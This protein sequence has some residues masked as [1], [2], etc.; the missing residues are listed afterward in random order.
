[1]T[2]DTTIVSNC[3]PIPD[4]NSVRNF[5]EIKDK[6]VRSA[7]AIMLE[8]DLVRDEHRWQIT[9]L[10]LYLFHP[11][12][13]PDDSTDK[14]DA[15]LESGKWY[16]R[17]DRFA[18]QWRIDITAGTIAGKIHAG[19]LIGA[20]GNRDGSGNAVKTI[21]HGESRLGD[22][23]FSSKESPESRFVKER[24]HGRPIHNAPPY[25]RLEKRSQR[26]EGIVWI[27]KRK[28]LVRKSWLEDRFK[29]APLRIAVY[30]SCA[31]WTS[32]KLMTPI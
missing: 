23:N 14:K 26:S 32:S 2:E 12:I 4:F 31:D 24:I 30:P 27:G 1:M 13:W 5:D 20:I 11:N 8:Y 29:N 25:L 17:T 9:A 21:L 19:L 22:W 28:G 10:E 18:T 16:A 6:F 3:A 7:R 15:Q